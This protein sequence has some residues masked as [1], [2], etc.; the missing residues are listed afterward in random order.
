MYKM[1]TPQ[2]FIE[3]ANKN[4][5]HN[6]QLSYED[7]G[8]IY[9]VCNSLIIAR[10]DVMLVGGKRRL[11]IGFYVTAWFLRDEIQI[12]VTVAKNENNSIVIDYFTQ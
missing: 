5:K 2:E 8:V 7:Y 9:L 10:F 1:K 6:F 11:W 3:E 4:G 12:A